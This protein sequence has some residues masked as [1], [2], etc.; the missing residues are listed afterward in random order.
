[1][2]HL[3]DLQG[4]RESTVTMV[5]FILSLSRDLFL[6]IERDTVLSST[7]VACMCMVDTL[8]LKVLPKNSGLL[9]WVSSFLCS[10]VTILA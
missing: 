1:M 4:E 6:L 8:T 10:H 7:G 5:S 9:A 3:L 2:G